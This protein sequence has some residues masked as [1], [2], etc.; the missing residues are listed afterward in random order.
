MGRSVN[1]GWMVPHGKEVFMV[2]LKDVKTGQSVPSFHAF[3]DKQNVTC[4]L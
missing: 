1:E 4:P 2:T 3:G